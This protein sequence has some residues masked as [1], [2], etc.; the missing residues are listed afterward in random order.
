MVL[1]EGLCQFSDSFEE[2]SYLHVIYFYFLEEVSEIHVVLGWV[3][4]V[5]FYSQFG[6]MR[7]QNSVINLGNL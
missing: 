2:Y 6:S 4:E 3:D 5:K 7:P 1:L